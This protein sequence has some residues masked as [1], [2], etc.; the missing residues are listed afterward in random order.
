MVEYKN[1]NII[2]KSKNTHN[3]NIYFVGSG[4]STKFPKKKQNDN[5]HR[6]Q[7]NSTK[8]SEYWHP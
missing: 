4:V 5:Y 7:C 6:I 1:T 2:N 3:I 8:Y